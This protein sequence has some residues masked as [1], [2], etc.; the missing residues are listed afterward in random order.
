MSKLKSLKGVVSEIEFLAGIHAM[1]SSGE[2]WSI[3]HLAERLNCSK[4]TV[5]RVA[6][7]LV[8]AGVLSVVSGSGRRPN[9]YRITGVYQGRYGV[10]IYAHPHN[11]A[12][13]VIETATECRLLEV[14]NCP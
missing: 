1:N 13:L 10:I 3:R 7:D 12:I 8:K 6:H 9:S 11:P 5:E 14:F 2:V 4:K